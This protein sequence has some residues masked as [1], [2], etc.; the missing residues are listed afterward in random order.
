MFSTTRISLVAALAVLA[1]AAV[2]QAAPAPVLTTSG[3]VQGVEAQG[4]ISYKGIAYAA[5]PVG[6]LR[7]RAPQPVRRRWRCSRQT[8]SPPTPATSSR[9]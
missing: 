9:Q 6:D 4:V 7:W 8:P 2:A 1:Q 5:A 3:A